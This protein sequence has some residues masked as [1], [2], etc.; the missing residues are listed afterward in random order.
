MLGDLAL[1]LRIAWEIARF[2]EADTA[3]IMRESSL[4]TEQLQLQGFQSNNLAA[5]V[6]N[7]LQPA[8]QMDAGFPRNLVTIPPVIS[9]TVANG[10]NPVGYVA[11]GLTLPRYQNWSFTIQR[12]LSNSLLLDI[13][14]TG[15]HGTRLPMAS[16][17]LGLPSNTN[18][19][20]ILG[21]GSALL[22]A[23][24]NSPAARA[25][26]ITA[27]YPGF[28]GI[29]AQALRPYPQYQRIDWRDWPMGNSIYHSLQVKLDKR[30]T[31]GSLFRVFYTRSKLINNGA[32]TSGS[33]NAAHEST[34]PGEYPAGTL[35]QHRRC[36]K[37]LRLLVHVS[38][39]VWKK[40]RQRTG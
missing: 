16:Q 4:M 26:G 9:P 33:N 14:Y 36:T 25:A 8:F 34:E 1:V 24:I 5:N 32:E 15:N 11:S 27:P 13:S 38:P 20:S 23:D 29:V 18:N 31:N 37:H 35:C 28:T 17:Y 10:L 7:G 30:F 40:P 6:T 12:Q 21:L 2:S 39:S 3:S 22:S 19:P